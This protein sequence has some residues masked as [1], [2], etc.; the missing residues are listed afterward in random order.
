M[1][2]IDVTNAKVCAVPADRFEVVRGEIKGQVFEEMVHT[3]P[4]H[5]HFQ[6]LHPKDEEQR[7]KAMAYFKEHGE[8]FMAYKDSLTILLYMGCTETTD[9]HSPPVE[10]NEEEFRN[11]APQAA[12][13]Y[14]FHRKYN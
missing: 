12:H 11:I 4:P 9:F 1:Q 13:W 6:L 14:R 10:F 7:D 3:I 8:L 2:I 5:F